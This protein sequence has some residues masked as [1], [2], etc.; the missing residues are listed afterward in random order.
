MTCS[1]YLIWLPK[2]PA[3][4]AERLRHV[5]HAGPLDGDAPAVWCA[6]D[7]DFL[8]F[9][10]GQGA[11]IGQLYSKRSFTKVTQISRALSQQILATGGAVLIEDY[12]GSYVAVWLTPGREAYQV[13]RDPSLFM[14]CYRAE[15]KPH[16]ILG[17][18]LESLEAAG[19]A[20]ATIAWERVF[21]HLQAN[22]T[23]RVDTCIQ[24]VA[25]LSPGARTEL[26]PDEISETILWSPWAFTGRH[27]QIAPEAAPATLRR[28]IC[29]TISALASNY[30]HI[31]VGLSGGLDSSIVC[32]ALA[33]GGH[34]FGALT[35][36]TKDPSGDERR[37]AKLVSD[38]TGAQ[39]WEHFYD[40]D[41][42]DFKR[43]VSA[44]L[45]RPVAKP[46]MQE[47]EYAYALEIEAQGFDAIFTG[48]GGDNVF[49][50]LH[51]AAP[52]VDRFRTEAISKGV[53]RTFLDMCAVTQCDIGTMSRAMIATLASRRQTPRPASDGRLLHR[54]R[55]LETV[56]RPL[57]PYQHD[58][59]AR[60][61]GKAG[62]IRL[63]TRIQNVIEGYERASYPPVIPVLLAQPIAETCLRIPSWAWCEG[64]INRSV[65]RQAFQNA[66]PASILR[67]TSKAGPDSLTA[68][69]FE[70]GR[71]HLREQLLGGVLRQYDIIDPIAV[72]AAIADPFTSRDQLI[73]R[74]FDLADAEAWG[75]SRMSK[76]RGNRSGGA[77]NA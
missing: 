31:V 25:E 67:R 62:H 49:C 18:D 3:P 28:T 74:L 27:D 44:H 12:W 19:C 42:I 59:A 48:N 34:S 7:S 21:E 39:L 32:A 20:V 30:R 77:A 5:E 72:E 46:F 75:R 17:S 47:I 13:L 52:I 15:T 40:V 24:S 38:M 4:K 9:P 6:S 10:D 2:G 73:Y 54:H 23:R 65:A 35:M 57:T 71:H 76:I 41:R 26:L 70:L 45:P 69:V 33:A 56:S 64:G 1:R 51:S 36:A 29:A 43:S 58:E 22:D 63:L 55:V 60:L 16:H 14:P 61:P 68:A 50:Y 66:L 11:L 53:V 8:L 37:Y